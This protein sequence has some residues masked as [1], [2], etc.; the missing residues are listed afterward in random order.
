MGWGSGMVYHTILYN[1][2]SYG[3][4]CEVD[5][6]GLAS[7]SYPRFKAFSSILPPLL[8]KFWDVLPNHFRTG[9]YL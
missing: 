2:I 9:I 5:A 1:T 8:L 6:G 3:L 7:C 4:C